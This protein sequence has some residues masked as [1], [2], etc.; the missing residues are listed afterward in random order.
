MKNLL[1]IIFPVL[2]I[3]S[4]S[5]PKIDESFLLTVDYKNF[6]DFLQTSGTVE[7]VNSVG[8]ACP[9]NVEGK[10]I[11]LIPDG[12][13]VHQGDTVCI[14]EDL[15][16]Q[17]RYDN[18]VLNLDRT[19]AEFRKIS[20]DLDLQYSILES[21]VK[22]NDAETEIARLDSAQL[23]FLTPNQLKIKLLELEQVEIEKKKINKKLKALKIIQQ[24]EI[25]QLQLRIKSMENMILRIEDDI[26]SLTVT[27]TQDGIVVRS[28]S[29][30]TGKKN[31]EG[32]QVWGNMPLVM[33]P[34]LE[35]MKVLISAPESQYKR[36]EIGD[37]VAYTFDALPENYAFGKI[38]K[39]SPVGTPIKIDS[40]VKFFEIE[41]S[42]D[43]SK[44]LPEPGLSANCKVFLKF[45]SN[46]LVIPQIAV[47]KIDSLDFVFI[48]KDKYF[49][50]KEVKTGI[51]NLNDILITSGLKKG[52]VISLIK[53]ESELIKQK[54]VYKIAK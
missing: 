29:W 37:S 34:N 45:K 2:L 46:S 39:K 44:I 16:L 26:K 13:M 52:D 32:D 23:K 41:A 5:G 40:K 43:S 9:R 22:N 50:Q 3:L 53:P 54:I 48:R 14:I 1:R 47:F 21:Q 11:Y 38:L 8:I 30:L 19:N 42:V 49:V 28:I 27:A 24:S 7:A 51:S 36:I 18:A 35:K 31:V 33:I 15:N 10:I 4:C 12:S 20:A 17:N 25:R 6:E